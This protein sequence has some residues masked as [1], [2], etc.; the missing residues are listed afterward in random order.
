VQEAG[1]ALHVEPENADALADAVLYL[2]EHPEVAEQL[3][4][5]GR[6]YVQG[7][8]DYD[9]LTAQLDARLTLM[10]EEMEMIS[11]YDARL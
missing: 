11:Q 5:R 1:A 7:R 2:C 8:F 6:T 3:G 9:T 10:L 4:Q